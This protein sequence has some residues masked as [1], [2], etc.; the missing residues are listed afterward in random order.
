MPVRRISV[1]DIPYRKIEEEEAMGGN[2]KLG[3]AKR[4]EC[5]RIIG[6]LV[7]HA[8]INGTLPHYVALCWVGEKEAYF[9]NY[10]LKRAWPYLIDG[11]FQF[12]KPTKQMVYEFMKQKQKRDLVVYSLANRVWDMT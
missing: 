1:D 6:R 8:Y 12:R 9:V 2:Q 3:D 4:L 11:K 5:S 10:K 7:S